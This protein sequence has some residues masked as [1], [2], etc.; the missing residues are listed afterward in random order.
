M[1]Q[2]ILRGNLLNC[3]IFGIGDGSSEYIIVNIRTGTP[4]NVFFKKKYKF[5]NLYTNSRKIMKVFTIKY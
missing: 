5:L 4:K 1:R 2:F 3:L